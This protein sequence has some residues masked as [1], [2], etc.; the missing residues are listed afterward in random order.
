MELRQVIAYHGPNRWAGV[1]TLEVDVDWGSLAGWRSNSAPV[2]VERLLSWLP[3]L[4]GEATTLNAEHDAAPTETESFQELAKRG[5]S[6]VNLLERV[7]CVLE[8]AAGTPASFS[9]SSEIV[10]DTTFCLAFEFEEEDLGRACLETARQCLLAA[11]NDTPF[12]ATAEIRK[13]VDLADD[14]RL[15]PSTR[16]ILSAAKS[17]GVPFRRLTTGSLVQLGEGAR[18]H[19]I[20]TAET[21]QTSSIGE[22]IAQDKELTKKLLRAVGVPVPQGRVAETADEAWSAA[23][24]IGFPVVFKPRDANHG[25]G[26]SFELTTREQ[27]IEAFELARRENKEGTSGVIVEQFARGLAHR[28][29]VVGDRLVAAARGQ[30]DVVIG[31][32]RSTITELVEEENRDPRRGENYTDPLGTIGLTDVT[33][34]ELKRQELTVDSV[35]AEGQEVLLRLNGDMTTDETCDVHPAVAERAVLAAQTI[36]L[37]I[38]GLDVI[39]ADISEP[40]ETQG[41]VIIEVNAGPGLAM[42]V[43]PLYGKPQPVGDAIVELMFPG[44]EDGRIPIIGISRSAESASIAQLIAALLRKLGRRVGMT[45]GAEVFVDGQR[46]YSLPDSDRD[47]IRSLLL[48]PRV[49]AAIFECHADEGLNDGLGCERT[50]VS[51]LAGLKTNDSVL[52]TGVSVDD[53]LPLIHSVPPGGSVVAPVNAVD[54]DRL[55]AACRGHV[56]LY[57]I[58]GET[59][60]LREHQSRGGRVAFGLLDNLV[61]GTGPSAFFLPLRGSNTLTSLPREN[62]LP[63]VAA[64]WSAG[65]PVE[66]L[67]DIL[68]RTGL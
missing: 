15:G 61:L 53:V 59:P 44:G 34:L 39:A 22:D 2:V 49:E 8:A 38:A 41:G 54:L 46:P 29:L 31:N 23:Q 67:R 20:W 55:I 30:M 64:A 21:D 32:G 18:Q 25:R 28:L 47:R 43:A 50:D 51:V 56:V 63:A 27:M 24:E 7:T 68:S 35:P 66:L 26:I 14:V 45:V 10:A 37:N 33:I 40:L 48:H 60:Q 16:A 65:V 13:L 19:R 58:E 42:H 36:G 4:G 62:L 6:L 12:D 5:L 9:H 1:S 57:S 17:R 11:L 3:A 52:P